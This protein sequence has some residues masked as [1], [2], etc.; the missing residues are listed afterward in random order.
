MA[1]RS[2]LIV[3]EINRNKSG[4]TGSCGCYRSFLLVE[5]SFMLNYC[6]VRFGMVR[7]LLNVWC[8]LV[9]YYFVVLVSIL[10]QFLF[11]SIYGSFEFVINLILP[12]AIWPWDQLRL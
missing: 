1:R 7:F 3:N 2:R 8:V 6:V 10:L 9:G 5:V 4:F 11:N 12:A